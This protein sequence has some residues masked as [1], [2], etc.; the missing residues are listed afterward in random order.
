MKE[1]TK[2]FLDICARANKAELRYLRLKEIEEETGK[3]ARRAGEVRRE[4]EEIK[5]EL[6]E[7]SRL[8]Q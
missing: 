8:P 5:R 6:G 2:E 1:Q 3:I 7:V 4:L